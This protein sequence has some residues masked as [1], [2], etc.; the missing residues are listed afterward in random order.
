MSAAND[1]AKFL[2]FNFAFCIFNSMSTIAFLG[3]GAMG[4][5]LA[6]GLI[7]ANVYAPHD[8][9]L[10]DTDTTRVQEL[11]LEIGTNFVARIEDLA[12]FDCV[13][14]AV[15][16]Q[17]VAQ[18]LEP[19]H[20]VLEARH[21]VVSIAAGITTTQLQNCFEKTVP[22]VRVMPN[23]PALVGHAASAICLGA[24]AD[25]THRVLAHRIFG[26]VGSVVDVPE[27][28][29]DAVTGLS[30]SGP[31]YVYIFIEALSDAGV[32]MG[33]PRD[34]A[35]KLAAQTVKG[36]AQ[37]V[38]ETGQHP[39]VLKDMVTSPAGTT[40]AALGV[41]EN[42]ALRGTVINAVEAATQ[43]SRELSNN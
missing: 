33:L 29:L 23:T 25:E 39:A 1:G 32:K 9:A 11:A 10:Y 6:R 7:R 35:T 42:G 38:L 15:K 13:V 26:A 20:R 36:A 41:L 17:V 40:I 43:R 28:L 2:I 27:H 5:A 8:I 14:V 12:R 22:I 21:S 37:M 30:G 19:L 3:A 4:A 16:P 34:V 18:A 31:A 24:H